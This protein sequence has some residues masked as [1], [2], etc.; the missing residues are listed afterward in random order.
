MCFFCA[1]GV[2]GAQ[3]CMTSYYRAKAPACVDEVLAQP[4]IPDS[5][6]S[7]TVGFLAQIFRDSAQ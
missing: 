7:T 2:A 3:Q 1:V 4:S 5:D 6:P